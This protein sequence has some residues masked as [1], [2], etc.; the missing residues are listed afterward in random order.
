MALIESYFTGRVPFGCHGGQRNS[1]GCESDQIIK[2]KKQQ[3]SYGR[4]MLQLRFS[5]NCEVK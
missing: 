2:Q 1:F 4:Y 5:I 3:I